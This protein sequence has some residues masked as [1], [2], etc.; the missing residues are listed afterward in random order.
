MNSLAEVGVGV[1]L[2]FGLIRGLRESLLV[3]FN[4]KLQTQVSKIQANLNEC[5]GSN[6]DSSAI[7]VRVDDIKQSYSVWGQRLTG[8]MVV[9]ALLST[10]CLVW[11]LCE[12][13][14]DSQRVVSTQ[15]AYVALAFTVGPIVLAAIIQSALYLIAR[16][17]LW[18]RLDR[19]D[20]F[21][22]VAKGSEIII[23]PKTP[24]P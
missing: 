5:V 14:K 10:L 7:A 3:V 13:A 12:S 4:N 11:F 16:I 15:W 19:Y 9:V 18:R 20:N 22:A 8:I 6:G 24:T 21:L 2:A 23:N 1:N 17:R